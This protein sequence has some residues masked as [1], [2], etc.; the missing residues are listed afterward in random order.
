MNDLKRL[1]KSFCV[2]LEENGMAVEMNY[3]PFMFG[4]HSCQ[5]ANNGSQFYDAN[6]WAKHIYLQLKHKLF[7]T[8]Y[9]PS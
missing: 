4:R 7:A 8:L 9:L 2:K 6:M 5:T 3:V 1:K